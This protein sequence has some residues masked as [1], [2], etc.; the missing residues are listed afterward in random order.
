MK[1]HEKFRNSIRMGLALLILVKSSRIFCFEFHGIIFRETGFSNWF[2]FGLRSSDLD[3]TLDKVALIQEVKTF[4]YK[5]NDD[6]KGQYES[7]MMKGEVEKIC[8]LM[9]K[10]ISASDHGIDH[11]SDNRCDKCRGN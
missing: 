5:S 11:E 4:G 1:W 3:R 9:C 2:S 7:C 6:V 8:K 10:M